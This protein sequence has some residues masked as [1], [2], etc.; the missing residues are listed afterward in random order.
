[1]NYQNGQPPPPYP[2]PPQ[3]P[4]YPPYG[5]QPVYTPPNP[6]RKLIRRNANIICFGMLLMILLGIFLPPVFTG[7]TDYLTY[8]FYLESYEAYSIM[9]LSEGLVTALLMML[10]PVVVIRLWIGIPSRV[11]FP[12]RR[13]RISVAIPAVFICLGASVIGLTMSGII[14]SFFQNAFGLTP[15]M[16]EFPDPVGVAASILYFLRL[17]LLP[18]IVEE[19]MFRGVIMQSLRRFGDTFA[20]ICS[21]ILFS[22]AHLN[23]IQGPNT[24]IIGLVIGFFVLRTGSL[25][26]GMLIHFVN[27]LLAV[28][29]DFA[30]MD[31][32]ARESE[33]FNMTVLAAYLAVGLIGLV[34]LLMTNS[35]SLSLAPSDYPVTE[36]GKYSAF[37]LNALPI[38]YI[39]VVGIFVSMYFSPY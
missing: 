14:A 33:I 2:Y 4:Q 18:A 20:L 13:P 25:R 9:E 28:L 31:M 27:N 29:I 22:L 32:P 7:I 24:L 21:S 5:Y 11:A 37:F 38:I 3:Y 6:W 39:L 35:G 30:M 16:P 12:M 23:L 10:V 15:K 34:V 1:M 36:R 17:V 8:T 26:T 19:L